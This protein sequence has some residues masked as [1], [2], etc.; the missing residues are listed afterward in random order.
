MSEELISIKNKLDKIL[1]YGKEP[2]Y[3]EELITT[4]EL[5]RLLEEIERLNKENDILKHRLNDM[6]FGDDC[7]LG[8]RY[9][10]KIG[11]IDFDEERKVYINKHNNEPFWHEDEK[12]KDYYIPDEEL[13]EYT[14][15]LEFKLQQ[16]DNIIKEAREL[17]KKEQQHYQRRDVYINA[18]YIL[19]ILDKV[20]ENK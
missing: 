2:V 1:T 10:R 17:I 15:Q 8:A 5:Q 4:G 16:R 19:E 18:N 9:L 3:C 7:E 13:S 14:K 20:E 6:V 11:Y 12:E